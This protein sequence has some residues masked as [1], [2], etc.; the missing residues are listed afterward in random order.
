MPRNIFL[1]IALLL[2]LNAKAIDTLTV[3]Q[4]Y[5][6]NVG[7]TMDYEIWDY[8]SISIGTG[9]YGY[10]QIDFERRIV[11]SKTYSITGD[12]LFISFNQSDSLDLTITN[13]DSLQFFMEVIV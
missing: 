2:A 6:F 12:T 10:Q 9:V 7:D 3:R 4:V 5:S 1:V 13:L 11:S 8:V